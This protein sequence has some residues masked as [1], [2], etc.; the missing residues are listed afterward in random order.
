LTP[1]EVGEV[2]GG[3]TDP[4]EPASGRPATNPGCVFGQKHGHGEEWEVRNINNHI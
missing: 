4:G 2:Q 1:A 3:P